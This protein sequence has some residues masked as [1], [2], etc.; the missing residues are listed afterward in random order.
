[1]RTKLK[2]AP[3]KSFKQRIKQEIHDYWQLYILL[4]LPLAY[5][6]IFK[7]LP[8]Y[9]VHRCIGNQVFDR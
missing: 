7:Y 4:I 8:I 9:D 1:M 6:L 2:N 5:F 3:K